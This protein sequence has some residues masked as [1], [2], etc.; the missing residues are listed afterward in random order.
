MAIKNPYYRICRPF[1]EGYWINS[2]MDHAYFL[3][4][5]YA[6]DATD[7]KRAYRLLEDDLLR[8]F[9]FVEP[10]DSNLDCYSHQ[11]YILLLR[12]CTEFET[13]A[14]A[15]LLA[16]GYTAS[17]NWKITDYSKIERASKLSEYA[18]RIPIWSGGP[19]VFTPFD[20]WKMGHSHS[21]P[22]YQAYNDVKHNRSVR[23]PSASLRNVIHSMG[24]VLAILFSQFAFSAFEPYH[25]IDTMDIDDSFFYS[26]NRCLLSVKP[27]QS[28]NPNEK[29]DFEWQA[30]A[31]S[32]G[33]IQQFPF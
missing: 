23:F 18:I 27:A 14:K 31:S 16:N 6:Q 25:T 33:A 13:N 26:Y 1:V 24:A 20:A 32:P 21:L 12:A 29:Y 22:W 2:T 19:K 10:T 4:P 17:K 7:L 28:W 8:V 11:L 3:D 5:A 9:D 30:I 15:V